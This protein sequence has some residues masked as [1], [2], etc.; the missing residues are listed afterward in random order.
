MDMSLSKFREIVKDREAWRAAVHGVTKSQSQLSDRTE[1][2]NWWKDNYTYI[3]TI[4][5]IKQQK[6][7]KKSKSYMKYWERANLSETERRPVVVEAWCGASQVAQTI[8]NLPAMQEKTQGFD[9]C[10]RKNP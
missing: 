4:D 9:P 10:I 6:H 1:L 7:A 5:T 3:H 8:K 2:M